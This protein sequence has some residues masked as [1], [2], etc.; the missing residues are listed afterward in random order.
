MR[1]FAAV[2]GVCAV[3]LQGPAFAE[4]PADPLAW[5][6]RIATA[7]QRLN[8]VGTF[9]YQSGSHVETSRIAHRVDASGEHE[10][11]EVLDGSPREVIRSGNEVRCVLPDQRTVIIDESAGR[12]AFPARLPVSPVGLAESYR[13]RKGEVG[14]VAGLEAQALILE[15]RDDLR[16]GHTLWAEMQ[17]G[18]L[19]KARTVNEA[20]QVIEQFAFSDVRIGG[21]ID[22][23]LL[24]PRFDD[25]DGWRVV[26]ARGSELS[27]AESGWTVAAAPPGYALTS[28]MRRPLGPERGQAVHMVFSDGLASVSVFIEPMGDGA[29]VGL[30]PLASGA[31]N[32]YKRSVNGHL[33]TALGEVPERAVRIIGDAIQ[34]AGQ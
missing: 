34:P 3:L 14:R 16:Y 15:P 1:G 8:Y 32:I 33:V 26:N 24:K 23:Q 13:I 28:V 9:M 29:Q 4:T 12:R 31:I 19:L 6:G 11:L 7:G 30:G 17:S 5:M 22:A 18:L 25:V 2:L 20:G 10:R 21:D 27:K